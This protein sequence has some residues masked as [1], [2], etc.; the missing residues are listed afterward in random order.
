MEFNEIWLKAMKE[1]HQRG[2]DSSL[3]TKTKAYHIGA[4]NTIT[5]I[6]SMVAEDC[7]ERLQY[8]YDCHTLEEQ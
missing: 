6:L 5:Q 4:Y 3:D 8:E 7:N 2:I 1:A